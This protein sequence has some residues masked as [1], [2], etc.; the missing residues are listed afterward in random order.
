[1]KAIVIHRFGP[2][3]V[4]SYEEGMSSAAYVQVRRAG[5]TFGDPL[6]LGSLTSGPFLVLRTPEVVTIGWTRDSGTTV[7]SDVRPAAP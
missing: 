1:M 5:G 4:L 2:P 3:E 6:G 7:L